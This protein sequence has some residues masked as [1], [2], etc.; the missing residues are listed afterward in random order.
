[1]RLLPGPLDLVQYLRCAQ[2]ELHTNGEADL[3]GGE[4]GTSV[5]EGADGVRELGGV[6]V[7][8]VP[9]GWGGR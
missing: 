1:M 7:G 4:G 9:G 5:N 6:R 3:G 8:W 2:Q